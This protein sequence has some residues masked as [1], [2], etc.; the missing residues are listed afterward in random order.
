MVALEILHHMKCKTRGRVGEVALKIDISKAYDRVNWEYVKSMM[1]KLG[2]HEKWANWMG[3]CM[4]SV[5]YHVQVNGE[6]VGLQSPGRGLRQGD[7]LSP[8]LFI[9]CAEGL[10]ILLKKLESRGEI[11]GIK[12]CRGAPILTHLLFADD[13]FL[14]CRAEEREAMTLL[15]A[16]KK[17]E[18]ASGQAINM[19]KSEIFFSKNTSEAMKEKMHNIFQVTESMGSSKY[20]GLPSIVGRKKKAIFNYIRDRIWRRIQNWSGKHLSKAGREVLIKSVAQSI[21]TYCMSSFLLPQT[22]GEEIQRMLNSFWWGSNR[23]NGRGIN[24]LS[25][26]KLTM[27]KE[28]GGMGF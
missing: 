12:V 3:L 28:Y 11:H 24:W 2:F 7:P 15:D 25:W 19:Q 9:I 22:L 17:Y 27:R 14:F 16:L 13:C 23:N 10:S 1:R 20:L 4:E 21:P 18:D 6:D 26:D 5:R 8:Y